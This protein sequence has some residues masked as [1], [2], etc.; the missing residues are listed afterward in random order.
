MPTPTPTRA[1]RR[2]SA[3]R[4]I[5]AV[6][7]ERRVL[8]LRARNI[9]VN[10]IATQLKLRVSKV[11]H[12]L[13]RYYHR[14]GEW[15]AR[16]LA[17]MKQE[18]EMQLEMLDIG[19]ARIVSL[20]PTDAAKM[21]ASGVTVQQWLAAVDASRK[22]KIDLIK[23]NGLDGITAVQEP[24]AERGDPVDEARVIHE[25]IESFRARPEVYDELVT[26]VR[27]GSA[28]DLPISADPLAGVSLREE[29]P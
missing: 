17:A 28:E 23:L 16:T 25:W 7:V 13:D 1:P 11:R 10:V 21:A 14:D 6:A 22:L 3:S 2:L 8:E 12:I 20:D 4:R 26:A 29:L 24:T 5:E 15:S 9:P 18:R 19:L 27:Q